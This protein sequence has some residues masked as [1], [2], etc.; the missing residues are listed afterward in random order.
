MIQAMHTRCSALLAERGIQQE[1]R[2]RYNYGARL[3]KEH[4]REGRGAVDHK[5]ASEGIEVG[6]KVSYQGNA[7]YLMQE[8]EVSP[9]QP[10]KAL[11]RSCS[12]ENDDRWVMF[13]QLKALA[14]D[15]PH[16]KLSRSEFPV[17]EPND[18]VASCILMTKPVLS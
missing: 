14:I 4:S 13:D 15:E 1:K 11:I 6:Q 3:T 2:S 17:Y 7:F 9:G 16:L 10:I 18:V 12:V 5:N 8:E